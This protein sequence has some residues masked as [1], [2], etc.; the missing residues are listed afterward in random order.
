MNFKQLNL[1]AEY[2]IIQRCLL[3]LFSGLVCYCK[4][5]RRENAIN[6]F[7]YQIYCYPEVKQH[8]S[9]TGFD[10]MVHPELLPYLY[11]SGTQT[12]QFSS[13]D[14]SG[15][16]TDGDFL[17]SFTKYIDKNG[18]YVFFDEFGP[19]CLY[20]QQ[21]NVWLY[22]NNN[23]R[24]L[25]PDAGKTRIKYY[26]DGEFHPR[27]DLTLDELFKSEKSPFTFPFCT[28]D[29]LNR[30]AIAYYPINFEKRL[31]I[32][33]KP[34]TNWDDRWTTWFQFTYLTYPEGISIK[35]WEDTVSPDKK[36]IAQWKQKGSDPKDTTGNITLKREI[37]IENKDSAVIYIEEHGSIAS[38]KLS[39]YPY[40][41]DIFFKTQIK[42][43]WDNQK[44]PAI[45]V[46]LGYFFGGGGRNFLLKERKSDPEIDVSTFTLK[47]LFFGFD[48]QTH[49]YYSY[50]PMPFWKNA[51]MVFINHSGSSINNLKCVINIKPEAIIDCPK[52]QT[53]HSYVKQ[54]LDTASSS[55]PY[56]IAFCEK[57]KGHVV[58]LNF[59]SS[60]YVMDGDEFTYIDGSRTH[61][62][63]GDGTED[64][65]NQGWGGSNYQYPL[66]GGLIN[67]YQGSY[68]I[69]MNDAY[70]F[71]KSLNIFYEYDKWWVKTKDSKTDVIVYYYKS[72]F[73]ADTL[74]Q[75]D[76]IDVGNKN[77]ESLHSYKVIG[78]TW[79]GVLTSCFDGYG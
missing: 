28:M 59:Y 54:I 51:R 70:V 48:G 42:I 72:S 50:W 22:I 18:E 64:D 53:G 24:I 3:Y 77:S 75:T 67:G 71:N 21:M 37:N 69:Y 26:S 68:R 73:L 6:E 31:K 7:N 60:N 9:K 12:K 63:Y 13:Y 40:N 34:T 62:I 36:L 11:P 10:A 8:F 27:I 65:H 5:Q 74:Q 20:R 61:Q 15:D 56:A 33:L 41:S 78:E 39:V 57:G 79:S 1:K 52:E 14:T 4:L 55:K 58:G 43:Y 46:P 35:S 29:S 44:L 30:F 66:W 76:Y 38:I 25:F 45:D 23:K 49:I 2:M 16:N 32:T 17:R 47:T 19:G